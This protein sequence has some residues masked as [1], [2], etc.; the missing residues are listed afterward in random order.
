M[1]LSA[2]PVPASPQACLPLRMA[3]RA[4]VPV[5]LWDRRDRPGPDFRAVAVRLLAGPPTQ[6]PERVKQLR[7]EAA[8]IVDHVTH[9]GAHVAVL[10]DDP[11]RLVDSAELRPPDDEGSTRRRRDGKGPIDEQ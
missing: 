10:F 4:G 7:V 8:T 2:P 6:V 11:T 1:V 3:L 9:V 5:L